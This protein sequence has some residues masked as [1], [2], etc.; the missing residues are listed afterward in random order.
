MV[1]PVINTSAQATIAAVEK[2]IHCFGIPIL[3]Y[4]IEA[5]P[6]WTPTSLIAQKNLELRYDHEQLIR[7]GQLAK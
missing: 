3:L 6:S 1:Y 4:T 2:R 5:L 7:H